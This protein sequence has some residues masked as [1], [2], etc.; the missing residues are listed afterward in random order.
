[1][2]NASKALL[3]A[4]AVLVAILLITIGI[5]IF[6]SA[7]DTPKLAADAGDV[8]SQRTGEAT[9]IVKSSTTEKYTDPFNY[10]TGKTKDTVGPGDEISLTKENVTERFTV[11][12]NKNGKIL[13]MPKYNI[14]LTTN[15][16][17]QTTSHTSIKFSETYYWKEHSGWNNNLTARTAIPSHFCC[18]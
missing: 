11:I 3:I 16:P 1:M 12:S 9:D 18:L 7:S 15:H 17:K 5:R 8:I 14:T 13:A 4:A 6:S 2:E 10:G